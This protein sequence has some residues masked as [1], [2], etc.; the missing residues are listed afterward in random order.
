MNRCLM[1]ASLLLINK[2]VIAQNTYNI[3]TGTNLVSS[4]SIQLVFETGNLT[5]NGTWNDATGTVT[6][7][8][9]ITYSGSGTTS[10]YNL[11]VNHASTT[12]LLNAPISLSNLLTPTAGTLNAN[13]N[14]TLLSTSSSTASVGAGP[15]NYITGNVIV[16]R[17]I[18]GGRRA[19]RFLSHPFTSNLAMSSLTDNIDITG[20]GGSPFTA[21][22]SN[23]PSAFGYDNTNGNSSLIS[24]PGWQ[25]LTAS[26]TL[27]A[28][29]AYRILIRGTKGQANSLNGGAYT[30]AAVTLD[31]MGPLNTGN[32]TIAL[33]NNGANKAYNF[34][35][36]PYASPVDLSLITRG[37]N[38]NA[39]FS[40]WDPS[41]SARG[42]YITQAFSSSYIL[43]SGS[44]FFTQAS[45]NTNNSILFTEASKSTGTAASLFRNNNAA[46]DK[47]VLQVN[48]GNGSYADKLALFIDNAN[49]HYTSNNDELWDAEKMA[50]PD[51]N[52]YSFS[53]DGKKLAIDRRPINDYD[54]I[55]LGFTNPSNTSFVIQVNELPTINTNHDFYLR[56]KWLNTT[57][58]L[59]AGMGIPFETTTDTASKGNNRFEIVTKLNRPLL[60]AMQATMIILVSPNPAR[61]YIHINYSSLNNQE[62]SSIRIVDMNGKLVKS[63]ELGRVSA[64]Q[65]NIGIAQWSNGVYT[66]Q[67]LNGENRQVQSILKQ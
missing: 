58:L 59:Q 17:Y 62:P 5:N 48:N 43:P 3:G 41:S 30:A 66:V 32:Q 24:D 63:M 44:A 31:W 49:S 20:S 15:A 34:I 37:S 12:S 46:E 22:A 10:F 16:Q 18:P 36:N 54:T 47:L 7:A 39:N 1:L 38:I 35:G 67:L 40:V 65:Q 19:F 13:G 33:I 28:K 52:L 25:A 57:T 27:D 56:D 29:T 55:Q 6:F 2:S 14:L 53:R 64:G 8:G 11:M 21:T 51:A 45:A 4:G 23:N 42:A 60:P 61:D 50:N 9:P 26:S